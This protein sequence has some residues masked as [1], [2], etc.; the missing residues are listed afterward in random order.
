VVGIADYGMCDKLKTEKKKKDGLMAGIAG[1][2]IKV[3]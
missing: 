2:W 1:Y 3:G